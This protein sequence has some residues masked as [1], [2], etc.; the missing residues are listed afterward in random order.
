MVSEL[1][2]LPGLLCDDAVWPDQVAGLA[3][4]HCTIADYGQ[5]DSITAMAEQVLQN[6][7]EQ[8]ALAGH[9]M[10]GRIALEVCR[11]APAR[12]T[13]L[14]LLDTGYQSRDPGAAG[15]KEKA[16]RM[17][18][19]EIALTRGMRAVGETWVQGMVHPERLQQPEFI[20]QILAMIERKTPE[21]FAAQIN[22]LLNR[23]DAT[24]VLQALKCPTLLI[25]GREDSWSPAARHADMAEL[26]A[27][28]SLEIIE[29]SGHM[30]TME[31]PA[32]VTRVM[33]DWL[34]AH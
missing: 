7:P 15:E 5:L 1:V 13:H 14:I 16:G 12:V 24:P 19:L 6:S 31:Q 20:E 26:V 32:A 21:I 8:F 22:A 33:R 28:S 17:A 29:H 34:A 10:G 11:L 23:P 27:G 9:S 3:P 2:L 18:L 25:C 4:V 30:S